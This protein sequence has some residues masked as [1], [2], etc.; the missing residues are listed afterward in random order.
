[1]CPSLLKLVKGQLIQFPAWSSGIS[2]FCHYAYT[3]LFHWKFS[4]ATEFFCVELFIPTQ[5][6]TS[7]NSSSWKWIKWK[8]ITISTLFKYFTK[9]KRTS[10]FYSLRGRLLRNYSSYKWH[11]AHINLSKCN[12]T[13]RQLYRKY[14]WSAIIAQWPRSLAVPLTRDKQRYIWTALNRSESTER[15]R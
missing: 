7:L 6:E 15:D 2:S 3:K 10:E 9:N 12:N 4:Y 5:F 1:M 11:L 14:L 8:R 13:N